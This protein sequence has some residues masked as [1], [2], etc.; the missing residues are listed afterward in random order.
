MLRSSA[1]LSAPARP[2]PGT[3]CC[4]SHPLTFL[5][6][7]EQHAAWSAG[8]S[9]SQSRPFS[10]TVSKLPAVSNQR[11]T[12]SA[13]EDG[14]EAPPLPPEVHPPLHSPSDGVASSGQTL[15]ANGPAAEAAVHK[16]EQHTVEPPPSSPAG[17]AVLDGSR[18]EG[19]P[20][21][22][23]TTD[24]RSDEGAGSGG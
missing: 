23:S 18:R 22:P 11:P 8:A 13:I 24:A 3:P 4:S 16:E 20:F 5:G 21:M 9:S 17:E 1:L 14:P 19:A 7:T 12:P 6:S 10:A 15:P 2:Q